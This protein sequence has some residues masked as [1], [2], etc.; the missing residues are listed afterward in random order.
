MKLLA[1]FRTPSEV[2][3]Y[4]VFLEQENIEFQL[5]GLGIESTAQSYAEAIEIWVMDE[6]FER[7]TTAI[8][9]HNDFIKCPNCGST[10]Y[11]DLINKNLYA[12]LKIV[13]RLFFISNRVKK[14]ESFYYKCNQC[15][16]EFS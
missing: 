3:D 9:K 4:L 12:N 5:S 7:A 8:N 14:H 13:L 10:D 1:K 16:H 11:K 2:D 6:D 15:H